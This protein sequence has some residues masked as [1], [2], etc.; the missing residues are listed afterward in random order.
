M[1][2]LFTLSGSPFTWDDTELVD[3]V[4][5]L[6][7][8][9]SGHVLNQQRPTHYTTT[10]I[11]TLSL[12]LVARLVGVVGVVER[13]DFQSSTCA[14]RSRSDPPAQ[15]VHTTT[16]T[17]STVL[18][19]RCHKIQ[20]PDQVSH[21]HLLYAPQAAHGTPRALLGPRAQRVHITPS[22]SST[23]LLPRSSQDPA[24]RSSISQHPLY[25][26]QAAAG[27]AMRALL[28]AHG[29]HTTTSPST[30]NTT[31]PLRAPQVPT[32][33]SSSPQP[34]LLALKQQY[35]EQHAH[36]WEHIKH[37][38]RHQHQAQRFHYVQHKIQLP[39]PAQHSQ[40]LALLKL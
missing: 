35:T 39:H 19:L 40:T 36:L 6:N 15:R 25:A 20:L 8:A 4:Q 38:P 5:G 34:S 27:E 28:G 30:A 18:P 14:R 37:T 33:T 7:H 22:T 32:L 2:Q 31:T 9:R 3:G 21:N 29:V 10:L 11:S 24:F 23:V 12:P 26:L 13:R 16:S 1:Q 17:S